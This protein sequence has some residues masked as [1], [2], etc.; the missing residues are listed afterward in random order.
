MYVVCKD[1]VELAIDRFVDEFEDA[2][3]VVDLNEVD[4]PQW[5][6]PVKCMECE[7]E[8]KFLIV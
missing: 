7:H 3:D 2:P 5:K 6:P 4:F 1:H 8:A